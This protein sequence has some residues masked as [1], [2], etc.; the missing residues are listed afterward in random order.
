MAATISKGQHYTFFRGASA[1]SYYE[2]L[3]KKRKETAATAGAEKTR[4]LGMLT[5]LFNKLKEEFDGRP[6][7][8]LK[9]SVIFDQQQM[10]VSVNDSSAQQQ[11][12]LVQLAQDMYIV[13]GAWCKSAEDAM[14]GVV[15]ILA[16]VQA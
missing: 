3:V 15:D 11:F 12:V 13:N 14:Q 1:M 4:Q 16:D 5:F 10:Q 7:G 6:L 2:D 8:K 9:M